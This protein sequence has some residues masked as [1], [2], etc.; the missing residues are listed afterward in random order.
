MI[1]NLNTIDVVK[2]ES[3]EAQVISL[4][5]S[6]KKTI[7]EMKTDF[8]YSEKQLLKTIEVLI[9]KHII[10]Y[11]TVERIYDFDAPIEGDRV[12]LDGNIIL[13]MTVFR[14]KKNN[15]TLVTRGKWHK[16]EGANFDLRRIIW[17]VKLGND[18]GTASNQPL[19]DL[20]KATALKEKKTKNVQLPEW[21][22]LQNKVVPYS[23][24]I[25]LVLKTIGDEYTDIY[26]RFE[27]LIRE[28][29]TTAS[30]DSFERV[31][32]F[33]GFTVASVI[34]TDELITTLKLPA[35]ERNY[36]NSIQINHIFKLSEFVFNGNEIPIKCKNGILEY[37]KLKSN[38][39]RT[40]DFNYYK[41]DYSGDFRKYETETYEMEDGIV[42][43]REFFEN[44]TLAWLN[45]LE[46]E[47][48]MSE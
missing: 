36:K 32:K 19:I 34:S 1:E 25:G 30:N 22:T 33:M 5:T 3:H 9:S 43:L 7:E 26:I 46:F 11:N 42:K 14:N 12:I 28:P 21:V 45:N 48:E 18:D 35:A 10:K 17:N 2:Y 47:V 16:L 4:I 41:M 24:N 39:K 23:P 8:Q 29:K 6:G 40:F 44:Y 13:P 27:E 20:I 38:G 37:I 31:H 15:Y